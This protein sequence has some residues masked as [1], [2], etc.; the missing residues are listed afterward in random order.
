MIKFFK[1][2]SEPNENYPRYAAIQNLLKIVYEEIHHQMPND[3]WL[4]RPV[5]VFISDGYN[6]ET[7][8]TI[9]ICVNGSPNQMS[10]IVENEGDEIRVISLSKTMRIKK[11]QI[12]GKFDLEM[13]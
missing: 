11:D 9:F 1:P 5:N 8:R 2:D 3:A 12:P 7:N 6:S 10:L 4:S 13:F